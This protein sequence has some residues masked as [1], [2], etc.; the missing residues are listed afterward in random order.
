MPEENQGK[1]REFVSKAKIVFLVLLGLIMIIFLLSN[2]ENMKLKFLF[3]VLTMD[4]PQ[5]FFIF[6][7]MVVGFAAG[8]AACLVWLRHIRFKPPGGQGDSTGETAGKQES[9]G[10]KA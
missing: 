7:F 3:G 8:F 2:L 6:I 10:P 4:G 9:S 5:A 1:K